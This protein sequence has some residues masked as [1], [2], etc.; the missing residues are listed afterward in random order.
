ASEMEE[1]AR[2]VGVSPYLRANS[3]EDAVKLAIGEAVPGDVVLLSPACTSWDMF[4]SYEERG[5][6]FKELV[7]RHYREP[8]LN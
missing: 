1:A 6:F 2:D 5:E 7:R 4:K 8:N 3:F